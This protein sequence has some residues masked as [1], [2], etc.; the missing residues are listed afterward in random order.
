MGNI[1]LNSICNIIILVSAVIIAIKN[2]YSFFKKPVDTIQERANQRE[3]EHILSLI[4]DHVPEE[5]ERCGQKYADDFQMLM[6][7]IDE[8]K[9]M[10]EAQDTQI[11]SIQSKLDLL[12]NS[13]MDM[14]RYDMNRI[15]YKYLPYHKILACD[16]KAFIKLYNDYKPMGGNTWID[17]LF[18]QIKDWETVD[19]QEDLEKKEEEQKS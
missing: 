18:D 1:D 13:Q 2:I 7:K 5:V 11:A 3:E 8:L 16:K 15:Y 4:A 12:N 10:Q 14:M 9:E 6:L 19:N 17:D